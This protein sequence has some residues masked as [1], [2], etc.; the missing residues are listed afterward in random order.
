MDFQE[1]VLLVRTEEAEIARL[2]CSRRGQ[3]N[4]HNNTPRRRNTEKQVDE[5]PLP[6]LVLFGLVGL[7]DDVRSRG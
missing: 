5:A 3:M 2:Q 1:V 6:N 7:A 4:S